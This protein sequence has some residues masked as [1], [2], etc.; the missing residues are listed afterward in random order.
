MINFYQYKTTVLL[1]KIYFMTTKNTTIHQNL[2]QNNAKNSQHF[3][4]KLI[5]LKNT[6]IMT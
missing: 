5:I 6:I 4:T 1:I 2:M 3:Q